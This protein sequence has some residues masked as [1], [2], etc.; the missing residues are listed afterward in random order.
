MIRLH[1]VGYQVSD[2][3]LASYDVKQIKTLR[4]PDKSRWTCM[5]DTS[6]RTEQ[7]VNL[8]SVALYVLVCIQTGFQVW[9]I[10]RWKNHLAFKASSSPC[11]SDLDVESAARPNGASGGRTADDAFVLLAADLLC[12]GFYFRLHIRGNVTSPLQSCPLTMIPSGQENSVTIDN[13]QCTT[14]TP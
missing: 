13:K 4:I 6:W 3:P 7:K 9:L 14:V 2:G 10:P 11:P 5:S 1:Q 12:L 8:I